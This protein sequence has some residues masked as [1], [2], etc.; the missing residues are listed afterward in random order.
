M[1]NVQT[2][3]NNGLY[4]MRVV[5]VV[6]T[7]QANNGETALYFDDSDTRKLYFFVNGIWTFIGWNPS[8]SL[9]LFDADGD[10]GI[11]PEFTTDEDVIRF[12]ANS[13]LM[14]AVS[15]FGIVVPAGTK[16]VV[17]GVNVASGD[18]YWTYHSASQYSQYY[19]DGALRMEM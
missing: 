8:G 10:T 7:W 4:E 3:L 18:T 9:V 16:I 13:S 12:Y 17:D 1:D 15:T 14:M 6:P 19:V 11:T 5:D 2:I